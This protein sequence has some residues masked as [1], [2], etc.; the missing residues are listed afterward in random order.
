MIFEFNWYTKHISYTA[1]FFFS[2][3]ADQIVRNDYVY[4]LHVFE[5]KLCSSSGIKI[6]EQY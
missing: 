2:F 1:N 5:W 3:P 6:T 4:T